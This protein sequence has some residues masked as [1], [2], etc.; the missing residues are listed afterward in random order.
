M[1]INQGPF[2]TQIASDIVRDGLGVELLSAGNVVAEVFRSDKDNS[3]VIATFG[4]D[5]PLVE[6]ERLVLRARRD[7]GPFE[8]GT[9]LPQVS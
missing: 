4:N 5:I 3:L 9:A 2:T 6:V 7:L 1:K 8:D